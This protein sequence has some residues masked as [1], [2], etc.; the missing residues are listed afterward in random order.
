DR[1]DETGTR[2]RRSS[3]RAGGGADANARCQGRARNAQ[4]REEGNAGGGAKNAS[5][6]GAGESRR[7]R[8]ERGAQRGGSVASDRQDAGA[9]GSGRPDAAVSGRIADPGGNRSAQ[10][11]GSRG[12]RASGPAACY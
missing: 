6:A 10:H 12:E 5:A 2:A 8:P 9:E 11:D 7:R 3:N 1:V 4:A